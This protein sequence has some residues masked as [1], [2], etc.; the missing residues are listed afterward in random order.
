MLSTH[1]NKTPQKANVAAAIDWH[2][3]FPPGERVPDDIVCF[4][5]GW[6]VELS[7]LDPDKGM[8]WDEVSKGYNPNSI[9]AN[10][11]PFRALEGTI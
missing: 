5:D 10:Q 7:Q 8:V 11:A 6:R 4:Q 9:A 1:Y 3:E 2:N